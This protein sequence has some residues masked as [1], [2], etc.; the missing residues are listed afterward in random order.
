MAVTLYHIGRTP[1]QNQFG[2]VQF[3]EHYKSDSTGSTVIT[4]SSVPQMGAA[5]PDYA[6]LFVTN[7]SVREVSENASM[8]DIT[9]TGCF[10]SGSGTNLPPQQHSSEHSV[11]TA[12]TYTSSLIWPAVATTPA[13]LQ[14]YAQTTT[15]VY[16]WPDATTFTDE[17]ADPA[18]VTSDQVITWTIGGE[19][20]ASSIPG[21]VTWLLDN[22]FVQAITKTTIV[23]EN[24][25]G[26]YY[27]ITSKKTRT[28]LPYAPAS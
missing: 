7:R 9:Y 27:Q 15:L 17:P 5:H 11:A 19:Q 21:I 23:K 12:T 22:A 20:P 18:T 6:F 4:D 24:V 10:G 25:A 16:F 28:L 1:G 2:L 3:T 14:F 8:L 13:S 26:H